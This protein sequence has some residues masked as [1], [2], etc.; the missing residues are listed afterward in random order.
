MTSLSMA[1][2]MR[3]LERGL[4]AACVSGKLTCDHAQL[5]GSDHNPQAGF[6]EPRQ[7]AGENLFHVLD[8][9]RLKLQD[10][11]SR[12]QCVRQRMIGILRGGADEIGR[13][14]LADR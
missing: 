7:A 1:S 14:F 3:I 5:I 13:A 11:G 8:R 6:P 12:N 10:R 4:G 2:V 9:D